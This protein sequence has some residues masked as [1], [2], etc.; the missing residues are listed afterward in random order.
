MRDTTALEKLFPSILNAT[1]A[2]LLSLP[3]FCTLVLLLHEKYQQLLFFIFYRCLIH[4]KIYNSAA[5]E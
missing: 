1:T 4:T 5:L 3:F 2:L